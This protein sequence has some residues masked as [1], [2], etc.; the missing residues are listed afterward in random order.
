MNIKRIVL[1]VLGFLPFLLHAQFTTVDWESAKG[2]S[3][4][5]YCSSVIELSADYGNYSYSAHIEYP[6]FQ[7]MTA[8]ELKRYALE[9]S[10][11]E[12]SE[13]PQIECYV[14]VQAKQPQLN[15]AFLPVVMRGKEYYRINSYKL[16]VDKTLK[17]SSRVASIRNVNERYTENSVLANGKWVR[18][19]VK[20]NGVYKITHAELKKMGF[21]N[22][23]SVRLFGYG[24]HMLPEKGIGE[25]TDDLQE[26]P[27][28]REKDYM[29]FYA[30]G[31]VKWEY[32]GS[33][34]VHKQNVYST[35]GC[36]FLTEGE[37]PLVFQSETIGEKAESVVTTYPDY[38]VI[39]NEKK[40]LCHYGRVLVDSY[41]YSMGRSV[42]YK[43]PVS[44]VASESGVIDLSFATN[45]S[46]ASDVKIS[47]NGT[48]A[49]TL[50]VPKCGQGEVGKITS[51]KF[52]VSKGFADNMTVK[53]TQTSITN[54]V[55]G[56]LDYLRVNYIRKLALRGSQTSFRG[57]GDG[58]YVTF[59]IEGCNANTRVWD[60]SSAIH[61]ELK[62]VLSGN[63]YSVVAPS[64]PE[65][66]L[67]AVDVKGDF[68]SVQVLGEVA[69]QNLHAVKQADMV[70]IVPSSG[71][72]LP[73]ANRLADAHRNIDGLSVEVVTAQQVYNE[74][75]SGTPDVTAYRRFMK[76]L[77]DRAS[78]EA[79]APKYLLLFGDSWY[80]NRLITFP[81]YKQD[82][83]LLCYESE[84]SVNAIKSYVLEDYMGFL[85]DDEGENHT[86]DMV[87][88]GVGRIPVTSLSV[89]NAVVD[90]LISYMQN[91][92]GGA[93]QNVIAL[94]GDD[95]D[96]D[97]PNQ[98]M[99]D[100]EGIA[101]IINE[102]Y[103]S[104][105]VDRIYWDDYTAEKT[106]TGI[107]Y[108][109]VTK[110]I[111]NRL[112]KGA[113]VVNYSGHGSETTMS[114]ELAWNAADMVAL[115]SPRLPFW[116]TAS[117][118]IGPFDRGGD[119]IAEKALVN[120]VG[121]AVGLL[122]TTRTVLQAHNAVLNKEF[123]KVLLSP[124]NGSKAVAVG[125][126]VRMAKCNLV[127]SG[128][129]LSENKLQ[130]V[131]LGDPALKL[132]LPEY[133]VRVDKINGESTDT[134]QQ[135]AAGSVLTVEGCVTTRDN[136]VVDGY[137]GLLYADLFDC[138]E[139]VETKDNIG[140]GVFTYTAHN[141][142]LSAGNDSVKA[143]RFVV[144]IPV[145]MDIS[146]KNAEGLLNF[147]ALETGNKSSAQG[148]FKN[149]LIGGTASDIVDDGIGPEIKVYLNSH[150]FV[151]GDKVNSTPCLLVELFDE[152]GINTVGSSIGHDI[153]AIVDN[154]PAHTYNLN[155]VYTPVAGDYTRG[156]IAFPLNSLKKGKHTLLLRAWDLNNN[157]SVAR[158]NFTVEAD[159][160]P[161]I[162]EFKLIERPVV[163]G[164]SNGFVIMHDRPQSEIE[165]TLE[166]FSIHGQMMW[167]NVERAVCGGVEYNC[168]WDV[169]ASGGAPLQTGVYVVRAYIKSDNGTSELQSLKIVVIN[170]KK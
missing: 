47:L 78:N 103:P 33:R 67:V 68:P 144:K 134:P 167:K 102:N 83:Y 54:L 18:V 61:R 138:A 129:E 150:S 122:T 1:I 115:D 101:A 75:S 46:V 28:W 110:A 82:D 37:T 88:L 15:V 125:D 62:G 133:R 132:K 149:F 90:K 131:L 12:L 162:T 126:A 95:G 11:P 71:V 8:A 77:Y 124:V 121:G 89:A 166:V 43:L 105:V 49:A 55:D 159:H 120:P 60:V 152:N 5:R 73:V 106:A 113:L 39:D 96:E 161:E 20:D 130:F 52:N 51:G 168:S 108:P 6:E 107:R 69:N 36:Y 74:F 24:G 141:K 80:D 23:A 151:N 48:T 143:G 158:I 66:E 160:V 31:V 128:K 65:K 116:V 2:D 127:D 32:S 53:L 114:H 164:V 76:M 29:L 13:L 148:N 139:D 93:W 10:Y 72:F 27:L 59:E 123:I 45:G 56:F 14:G 38:A 84:N 154:D 17:M 85:D 146:Y 57:N 41:D 16:V 140:L 44:D 97:I 25:L 117:C 86:R 92:E 34:F 165:V 100:A 50:S 169:T 81:A 3:V 119:N 145:P 118:D 135:V 153:V 63:R 7:K 94:L 30:N 163:A 87:D 64:A 157:S 91:K 9:T 137:E 79:E 147:Y 35:Y 170:N 136:V 142:K 155:S 156:T 58:Q 104:F 112:D 98:H 99:K 42:N 111:Y 19:S 26:V 40:S 22:P 109:S 21:S 70:I 4:L